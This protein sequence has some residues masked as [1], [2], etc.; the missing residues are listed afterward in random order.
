MFTF[1][2]VIFFLLLLYALKTKLWSIGLYL[3][4]SHVGAQ[5]WASV[6][7]TCWLTKNEGSY[8]KGQCSNSMFWIFFLQ[9]GC[10]TFTLWWFVHSH[11]YSLWQA[12]LEGLEKERFIWRK[13]KI[14]TNFNAVIRMLPKYAKHFTHFY[15]N[16]CFSAMFWGL[17]LFKLP[18][19]DP[20]T[21]STVLSIKSIYC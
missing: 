6:H 10:D 1:W 18:P 17:I 8:F 2:L 7:L 5:C 21:L 11:L 4:A 19:D 16:L 13:S 9:V 14:Q 15:C 20:C 3:W 12:T